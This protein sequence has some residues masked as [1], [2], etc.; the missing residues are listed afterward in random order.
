MN[1]EHI[2]DIFNHPYETRI[3]NTCNDGICFAES[4]EYR[5]AL[6]QIKGEISCSRNIEM[7]SFGSVDI[8]IYE[9]DFI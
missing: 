3:I 8:T 9:K 5:E 7:R 2:E 4:Y 1:L 6:H